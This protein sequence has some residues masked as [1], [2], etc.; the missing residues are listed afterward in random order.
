MS[1]LRTF[2]SMVSMQSAATVV[3]MKKITEAKASQNHESAAASD[4]DD[5]L[6]RPSDMPSD[7]G[8]AAG[9]SAG[10]LVENSASMELLG[11]TG[12]VSMGWSSTAD[13]PPAM[14]L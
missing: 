6:G 13:V 12:V 10:L 14:L 2:C 11:L 4:D 8:V 1:R 7:A 3:T 9:A 5:S